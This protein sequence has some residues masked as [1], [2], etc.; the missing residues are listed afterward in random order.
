VKPPEAPQLK[1]HC[2]KSVAS[3]GVSEETSDVD[4]EAAK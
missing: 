2:R 3:V 4:V 1:F